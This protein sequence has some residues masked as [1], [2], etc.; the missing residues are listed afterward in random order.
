MTSKRSAHYPHAASLRTRKGRRDVFNSD[1]ISVLLASYQGGSVMTPLASVLELINA[2]KNR[3]LLVAQAALTESQFK[4][5]KTLFLDEFGKRGLE[6]ELVQLFGRQDHP[7][8][9]AGQERAGIHHAR[10]EVPK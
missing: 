4:A 1:K 5:F 3:V 8:H 2:R 6:S 9:H 10:E 7:L